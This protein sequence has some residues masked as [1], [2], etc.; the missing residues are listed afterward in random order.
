M[1]VRAPL[2]EPAF[3]ALFFISIPVTFLD[4]TL[5]QVL[6]VSAIVARYPLR[7]VAERVSLTSA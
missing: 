7:R 3:T 5:A 6:W 1:C 2:A 4:T